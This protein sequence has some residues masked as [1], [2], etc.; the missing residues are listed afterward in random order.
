MNTIHET[1]VAKEKLIRDFKAVVTD[2]E[3]LLKATAN[4]TG[5]KVAAVRSRIE[6]NLAV[7]KQRLSDLEEGLVDKTKAAV[8]ATDQMVQDNPW[9]AVGIAAAVGFLLGLLTHRR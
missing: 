4:Q 1:E 7:A 6:E 9:K 3:D 8:R 5:E 2:A